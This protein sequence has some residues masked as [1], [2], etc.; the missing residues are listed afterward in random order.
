MASLTKIND[1]GIPG[2]EGDIVIGMFIWVRI[3]V[4][5]EGVSSFLSQWLVCPK[6]WAILTCAAT[7]GEL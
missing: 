6:G 4:R 7:G 5:E 1:L 2:I 3:E